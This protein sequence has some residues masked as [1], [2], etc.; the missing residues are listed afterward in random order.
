MTKEELKTIADLP[1]SLL[2]PLI[3]QYEIKEVIKEL[4]L[5]KPSFERLKQMIPYLDETVKS[6]LPL[7]E[8]I[9]IVTAK[10]PYQRK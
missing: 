4:K 9:K 5:V 2:L 3:G 10:Q 7:R 1:E 8:S 6:H